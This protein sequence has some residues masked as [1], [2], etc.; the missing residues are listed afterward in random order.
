MKNAE[1]LNKSLPGRQPLNK[2]CCCGQSC[3]TLWDPMDCS[4]PGSSVH[5]ITQARYWTGFLFPPPED[6]CNPGIKLMFLE[7]PA[8]ADR[9]LTHR[10]TWEA[11]WT[12]TVCE[13]KDSA[14][15]LTKLLEGIKWIFYK[16][17]LYNLEK[18]MTTHSSILAWRIPWT[19]EPCGLQSMGSQRVGHYWRDLACII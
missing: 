15:F 6:L 14:T 1:D 2:F 10:V 7:S 3:P 13:N 19:E 8:L 17:P 12:S 5:W 11:L 4:P 18:G 16:Y 9:L